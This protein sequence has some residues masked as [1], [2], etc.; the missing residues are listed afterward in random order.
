MRHK[1]SEGP[2]FISGLSG[3][4]LRHVAYPYFPAGNLDDLLRSV[5]NEVL[6]TGK[7]I[8]ASKGSTIELDGTLLELKDP[9]GRLS[10]TE[11]RGKLVSGL[12]ELCWFLAKSN[13]LDFI[14]YY[15]PYYKKFADHGLI[16]GGYGPRLFSW[17]K[18]FLSCGKI[19]Q[20]EN[21]VRLLRKKP[22]TRQAVIQLFDADDIT[23]EHKDI[24][25][26]C[27]LQ[28][29]I[30]E[31]RLLMFTNMRSNDIYFGLPHDIFS[32]TM[33]Q[34]IMARTLGIEPGIYKHAVGSLHLYE[35][36]K[37]S[38]REFIEEG[39]QSTLSPM[40]PMPAGDPWKSIATLLEVESAIRLKGQFHEESVRGL[41]EYW[42]DLIRV[43][44]IYR[45]KR[46]KRY[47]DIEK[48]KKLM[49]SPVY[50][51]FIEMM[52]PKIKKA[53]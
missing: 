34:E 52:L 42:L 13:S 41:D 30:R 53:H 3:L 29:M 39:Y 48:M 7:T 2:P 22:S 33:L 10:R 20:I 40:P 12:G 8:T 38:A 50:D 32:F 17:R 15:I 18:R 16:F 26:T 43:L 1:E 36:H 23:R 47:S 21:V 49:T 9:R 46:D 11:T 45:Y 25:C 19:N 27:T 44:Q 31:D 51:T 14:H 28:F 5:Y 35:Q 4:D 6:S 24:P 37:K